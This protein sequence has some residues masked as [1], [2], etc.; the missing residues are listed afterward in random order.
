[1][2]FFQSRFPTVNAGRGKLVSYAYPAVRILAR[3][4]LPGFFLAKH[5]GIMRF[6]GSLF[7][8]RA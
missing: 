8:S 4:C 2:K 7:S 3:P 5:R 6:A 1:M